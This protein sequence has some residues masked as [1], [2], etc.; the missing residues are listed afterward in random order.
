MGV[1]KLSA[2]LNRGSRAAGFVFSVPRK[3]RRKRLLPRPLPPKA[4]T[5]ESSN[6]FRHCQALCVRSCPIEPY[7][8][9]EQPRACQAAL[10]DGGC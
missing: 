4:Q 7:E 6:D 5:P 8:P 3:I 9:T 1:S 2:S 10:R